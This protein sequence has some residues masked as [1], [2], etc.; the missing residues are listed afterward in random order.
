MNKMQKKI[1]P[2][3][4]K[5]VRDKIEI[6]INSDEKYQY[7]VLKDIDDD[8]SVTLCFSSP[9]TASRRGT[10]LLDLED[11]IIQ[12]V[13]SQL[14]IWC[15]VEKDKSKLRKLRGISDNRVGLK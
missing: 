14:R 10:V 11:E 8:G 7:L 13:N 5:K 3:F 12:K 6:I 1:E 2:S 4:K 15:E 9:I